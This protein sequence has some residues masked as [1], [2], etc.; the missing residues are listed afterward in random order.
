MSRYQS[1]ISIPN[2]LT[3]VRILLTPLFVILVLGEDYDLALIIF[4]VAGL[5]DGLDGLIARY[6]NQR[7][8][9]G[10][11][12]AEQ[13]DGMEAFASYWHASDLVWLIIF[14]LLYVLR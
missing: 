4:I 10:A 7:T 6:M 3:L 14:P 8:A 2:I 1:S 5:S 11:Y 9:I 13:H 12:S